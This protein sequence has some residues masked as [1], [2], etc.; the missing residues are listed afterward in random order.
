MSKR[1]AGD[2]A[3]YEPPA[4]IRNPELLREGRAKIIEAAIDLFSRKGFHDTGVEEV[5]EAAG[6]TVGALYKYVRSKHDILF[7]TSQYITEAIVE[8]FNRFL[9][10]DLEPVDKLRAAIDS[11]FRTIDNYHRSIRMNYRENANL[12]REPRDYLFK[13]FRELREDFVELLRPVAEANGMRDEAALRTLGDNLVSLGQMWAVN[14]RAYAE[15]LTLDEF[16]DVQT[17]LALRQ[18]GVNDMKVR[19]VRHQRTPSKTTAR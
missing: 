14:H 10:S 11:Y 16:I 17:N 5:A 6:L 7:L 4:R 19:P 9:K 1:T 13:M 15:H 2:T 3:D 12:D 8:R 18:L